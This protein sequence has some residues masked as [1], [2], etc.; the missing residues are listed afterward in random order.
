VLLASAAT[1][2]SVRTLYR[3]IR[4]YE[5]FGVRG[6]A[7]PRPSNAGQPRV[8]VSRQFDRA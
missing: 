4:R 3:W 7:R 8:T 6:L 1:D 5:D 2:I